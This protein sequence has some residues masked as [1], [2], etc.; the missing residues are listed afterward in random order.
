MQD[1]DLSKM[2]DGMSTTVSGNGDNPIKA[3]YDIIPTYDPEQQ[4][5]LFQLQFFID[6]WGLT[7]VEDMISNF[8]GLMRDNKNLSFFGTK[9]L[10]NLLSAYTQTDLIRGINIRANGKDED[11]SRSVQ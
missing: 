1:F 4:K 5:I 8:T 7:H 10:Q 6:K 9:T 3:I 11:P 2:F